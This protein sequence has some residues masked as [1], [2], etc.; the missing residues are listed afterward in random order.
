QVVPTSGGTA[1][2][3][4]I[5]QRKTDGG[6]A[7]GH[8]N[9]VNL[10]TRLHIN[11]PV[12]DLV[13]LSPTSARFSGTWGAGCTFT[14]YME[15][16]GEPGVSSGDRLEVSYS[17]PSLSIDAPNQVLLH[18]NN[19][20]HKAGANSPP[21]ANADTASMAEKASVTINVL[22]NDIPG[23]VED[24]GQTL[25]VTT[26]GASTH[27]TAT[28]NANGTITYTPT[29]AFNGSDSFVYTICDNGTT[30]GI[31]DPLCTTGV[32]DVTISSVNDPPLPAAI[33][34]S[35]SVDP[36]KV[37]TSTT[38]TA[39]FT[40]LD[41]GDTHTAT[42]NWGDGSTSTGTIAE[43]SGGSGSVT[44]S[45]TYTAA[46][47]YTVTLTITDNGGLAGSSVFKSVAV[48]NPTSTITGTGQINSPAG[49]YLANSA[50]AGTATFSS[51]SVKYMTG[52]T[53]P[54]GTTSFSYTP[55]N[56][57]FSVSSFKW[58]IT[59]GGKA[60]YRGSGTVTINGVSQSCQ[61][62]VAALDGPNLTTDKFRIKIWTT[63]TVIY[64][65]QMGAADDAVA[66]VVTTTGPS[67]LAVK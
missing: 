11:G 31:A 27:G 37:S 64:D 35:G 14:V 21:V 18:G 56:L 13:I 2:F 53:V 63:T 17:C 38:A 62:L 34:W 48:Y 60:W 52:A 22:A 29:G 55:A 57:T 19:Q 67:S 32:V 46:G 44:G 47:L 43:P 1:S 8:F 10:T 5:A 42:W 7:T 6:P 33:T 24:S 65:D 50:L 49:S 54:S 28:L 4:Y 61:F 30:D 23:P 12:N 58:L 36:L 26:V 16:N 40:D 25:T 3:G 66:T 45:H 9:Y 59:T 15:D 20:M 39:S 41:S 51:I